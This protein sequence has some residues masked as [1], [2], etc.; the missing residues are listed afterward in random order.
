MD[1]TDRIW[2]RAVIYAFFF[3]GAAATVFGNRI[4]VYERE[5]VTQIPISNQELFAQLKKGCAEEIGQF[6]S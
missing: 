6:S 2:L 5:G 4:W 3:K 1:T